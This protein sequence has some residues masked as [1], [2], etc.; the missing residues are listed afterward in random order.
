M[1]EENATPTNGADPNAT[2]PGTP[3]GPESIAALFGG[4]PPPTGENTP[5]EGDRTPP[6]TPEEYVPGRVPKQFHRADGKHDYEGM[7]K[8][9]FDTR[10]EHDLAKARIK[11]LE[12]AQDQ[13]PGWEE[14]AGAVDWDEVAKKAPNAYVKPAEGQDNPAA[15]AMLRRLH[16]GG[17]PPARAKKFVEDYYSDLSGM[18]PERKPPEELRKSAIAYLRPQRRRHDRRGQDVARIPR[19]HPRLA[20]GRDGR[21]HRHAAG[22]AGPVG[23]APAHA[24]RQRSPAERREHQR[25]LQEPRAGAGRGA[26]AA[27]H[28][29]PGRVEPHQGQRAGP[30]EGVRHGRGAGVAMSGDALLS[31]F[32]RSIELEGRKHR[33]ERRKKHEAR[34]SALEEV[35]HNVPIV[36]GSG[37][38]A[39]RKAPVTAAQRGDLRQASHAYHSLM[40]NELDKVHDEFLAK[41]AKSRWMEDGPHL[42]HIPP[43]LRALLHSQASSLAWQAAKTYVAGDFEKRLLDRNPRLRKAAQYLRDV[44]KMDPGAADMDHYQPRGLMGI[45]QRFRP[46]ET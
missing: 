12:G 27:R 10:K 15:T 32:R 36:F 11:E 13:V 17:M 3:G 40:A 35:R 42:Q 16:E 25:K 30:R 46:G 4:D 19:R 45:T 5:P 44:Y 22:R 26:Q 38:Q 28:A 37:Y 9:W 31:L 29:G 6:E 1:A 23:A 2:P 34:D 7:A 21:P 41:T 8:S 14:Y 24:R 43:E 18:I 33:E 39:M 20:R